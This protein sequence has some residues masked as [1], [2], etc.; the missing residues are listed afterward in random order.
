MSAIRF[1]VYTEHASEMRGRDALEERHPRGG[2]WRG[3]RGAKEVW[4]GT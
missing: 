2:M 3:H 4:Y 1:Y